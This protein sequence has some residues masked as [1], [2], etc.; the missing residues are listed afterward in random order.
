[1]KHISNGSDAQELVEEF[2]AKHNINSNNFLQNINEAVEYM[3]SNCDCITDYNVFVFGV[4]YAIS[5]N[6]YADAIEQFIGCKT[7][8]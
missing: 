6:A 2:I 5:N 4:I 3:K 1:M 8:K 7:T